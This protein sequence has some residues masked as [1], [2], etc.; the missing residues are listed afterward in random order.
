VTVECKENVGQNDN[1]IQTTTANTEL[2]DCRV[3]PIQIGFNGRAL[4][5]F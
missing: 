4:R 3:E 1:T 5:K 2:D